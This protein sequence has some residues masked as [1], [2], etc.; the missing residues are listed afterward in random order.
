MNPDE[1]KCPYC[2][3]TIK[4][5]AIK[6]RYCGSD[7]ARVAATPASPAAPPAAPPVSAGVPPAGYVAGPPRKGFPVWAIVAIVIGALLIV[8]IPTV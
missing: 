8:A 4:A 6:C 2:A 3:E 5:D 1:K 7:L